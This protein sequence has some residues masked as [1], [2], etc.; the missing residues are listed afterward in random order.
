[1]RSQA[2]VEFGSPLKEIE[3]PTPE[4]KG[5]EVLLEVR[6]AG[7]CHSDVHIQDGYFDLG[8][9]N[10]LPLTRWRGMRRSW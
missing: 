4:P 1:M 2:V 10:R 6:H 9:G 8:G 3:A 7:V 5:S